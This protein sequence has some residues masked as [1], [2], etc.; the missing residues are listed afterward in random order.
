MTAQQI[1]S[2]YDFSIVVQR[3]AATWL[4]YLF[5]GGSLAVLFGLT[6]SSFPAAF[7]IWLLL[8]LLYYP[9]LEGLWGFT[10]G[11]LICGLIVVNEYGERPGVLKAII[12][13]LIR[14]IEVN[15]IW[16]G[17]IPAGIV[18]AS[19]SAHQR[20]GDMA[21]RTYVLRM[22]D[23][24]RLTSGQPQFTPSDEF[25]IGGPTTP[26]LY[27]APLQTPS[28][29]KSRSFR[30]PLRAMTICASLITVIGAIEIVLGI[31]GSSASQKQTAI[32]MDCTQFLKSP[33]EGWYHLTGCQ[34]NL[35]EAAFETYRFKSKYESIDSDSSGSGHVTDVYVPIY[36]S[37]FKEGQRTPL[38]LHSGDSQ[39]KDLV[40]EMNK[41]ES[42]DEKSIDKW[43][44]AHASE[45]MATRDIVGMVV[46]EPYVSDTAKI[47]IQQIQ[48]EHL[49]NSFKFMKEGDYPMPM[50]SYSAT[51][52]GIV[53]G[54]IALGLWISIYN[55]KREEKWYSN[56]QPP[57]QPWQPA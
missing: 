35:T 52:G 3:W 57:V 41:M 12:R 15:P 9:I 54:V 42:A 40:S 11:K 27:P 46:T 8:F 26:P 30:A 37:D 49:T 29:A 23:M 38:L 17:G 6:G 13:T 28:A 43:I 5:F 16:V 25:V 32:T 53:F 47:E 55:R 51:G 48:K 33:K 19:S 7:G 39:L 24:G 36:G 22:S 4:D 31:V 21:A 20:L 1:S 56:N 10:I 2:S 44:E 50:S 14:L 18:V 34:Y 45:V